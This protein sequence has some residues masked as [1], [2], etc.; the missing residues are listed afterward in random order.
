M[1]RG[2][3]P[4]F[5][6]RLVSGNQFQQLASALFAKV[7]KHLSYQETTDIDQVCTLS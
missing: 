6:L 7:G 3:S 2:S 4:T 1:E 5:Y